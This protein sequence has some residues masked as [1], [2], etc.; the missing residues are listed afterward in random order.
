MSETEPLN[1]VNGHELRGIKRGKSTEYGPGP[2]KKWRCIGCALETTRRSDLDECP[3][4]TEWVQRGTPADGLGWC[5]DCNG[6]FPIDYEKMADEHGGISL[7]P[8]PECGG[9]NWK[10]SDEGRPNGSVDTGSARAGGDDV[11]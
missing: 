9:L 10:R 2:W 3:N 1:I 5:P 11:E 8:C 4:P 6:L 7:A